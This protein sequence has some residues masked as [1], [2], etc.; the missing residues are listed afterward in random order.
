LDEP[1]EFCRLVRDT[2]V[3]LEERLKQKAI[4]RDPDAGVLELGFSTF[5]L[6]RTNRSGILAGGVI[7]GNDQTGEWKIDARFRKDD[8]IDRI[9]LVADYRSRI[10]L[11]QEDAAEYLQ[12]K[13]PKLPDR[14]LVY[15]DPPYYAKSQKLYQHTYKAADHAKIAEQV[16]KIRQKWIVSYDN[17][18]EI[19]GL[20]EDFD[21]ET[22]ALSWSARSRYEGSEVMV[23]GPSVTRPKDVAISRGIAA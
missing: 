19:H 11:T 17:C 2:A 22:F 21:R 14:T 10:T 1:E 3:T 15:L 18:P 16:A 7:G 8:L 4:Q 20:Y 12:T 6:N 5:F 13:L 23:F 9:S